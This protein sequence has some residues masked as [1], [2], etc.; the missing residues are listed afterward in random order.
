MVSNFSLFSV[1]KGNAEVFQQG[2]IMRKL[3]IFKDHTAGKKKCSALQGAVNTLMENMMF[4]IFIFIFASPLPSIV[5][6]T[7]T[8]TR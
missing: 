8:T 7:M 1:Y 4:R 6:D 3:K 2:I 5:L